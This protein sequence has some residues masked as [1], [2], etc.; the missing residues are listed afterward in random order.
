MSWDRVEMDLES[1]PLG[2]FKWL[3]IFIVALTILF[4]GLGMVSKYLSVNA[5]RVITKSSFQYK[6]GMEQRAAILQANIEELDI[7]LSRNP[8][9]RADLESQR[10]IL[11][12]QLL[13]ITINE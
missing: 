8:E 12:G 3:I 4:G 10:S 11:R 6:E 2:L 5:D 9:N 7:L 13:A 1:G